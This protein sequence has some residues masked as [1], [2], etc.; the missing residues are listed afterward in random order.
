MYK[1]K[2]SRK[3]KTNFGEYTTNN[4]QYY[5]DKSP[6]N[7]WLIGLKIN[8]VKNEWNGGNE[9]EKGKKK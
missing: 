4:D 2:E 8:E 9:N 7:Y 1:R 3:K 6:N 5:D